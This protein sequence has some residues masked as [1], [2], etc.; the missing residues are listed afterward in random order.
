MKALI[1]AGGRGRRLGEITE[2]SNKCMLELGGAPVLQYNLERAAEAGVEEIVLVV[3]YRAE[4]IINRYGIDFRGTRI[5]YVIQ[6]EQKGLVHAIECAREAL[7]DSDFFLLLGDEVLV[8]ARHLAMKERFLGDDLFAACGVL[9]QK[10]HARIGRTYT[11]LVD[12]DGRVFRLIEKPKKALNDYQ[13]TGHCMFRNAI[14]QYIDRTPIHP[15]RREKELPDL[16]QCAVDDGHLVRILDICD[17]YTNINSEEDLE[18]A[19]ALW[20]A[21]VKRGDSA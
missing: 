15:E 14:F 16:V 10:E 18:D 9:I 1:L 20:G 4:E 3:G 8:N 17:E 5:R 2:A 13:G 12:D 6:W 11:V 7:G 19:L 21:K